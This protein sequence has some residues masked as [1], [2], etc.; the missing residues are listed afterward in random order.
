MV[1]VGGSCSSASRRVGG[2]GVSQLSAI[3]NAAEQCMMMGVPLI[4]N[5][6]VNSAPSLAKALGAGGEVVMMDDLFAGT[7]EAPGDVV[8]QNGGVY[9]VVNPGA[10]A[11][12]RPTVSSIVQDPL[13]LDEDL[14]DTS[15]P[16]RGSVEHVVNHLIS[17]LKIAMAY[18]GSPDIRTLID[19]AEFVRAD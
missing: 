19:N 17:G 15:V 8:H 4:V 6:G 3:L 9:K 10:K 7:D 16:Y 12:H 13:R 14:V 1:G 11:Q 2:V 18:S 5:G